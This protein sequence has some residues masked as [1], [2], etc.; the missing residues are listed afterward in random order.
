MRVRRLEISLPD[1]YEAFPR[2][3]FIGLLVSRPETRILPNLKTLILSVGSRVER[4]R[5][6]VPFLHDQLKRLVITFQI[7]SSESTKSDA[8]VFLEEI[9]CRATKLRHVELYIKIREVGKLDDTFSKFFANQTSLK[10][11]FMVPGILT[12]PV[13][14]SLSY[15]PGLLQI[16]ILQEG[17]GNL[18]LNASRS[19]TCKQSDR[20]LFPSLLYLGLQTRAVSVMSLISSHSNFTRLLELSIDLIFQNDAE[21]IQKCMEAISTTCSYLEKLAFTRFQDD[22]NRPEVLDEETNPITKDTIAS[23]ASFR[24]LWHFTLTHTQPIVITDDDLVD[25]LSRSA[26]L[27]E[28]CLNPCALQKPISI[29]PLP[30]LGVLHRIVQ[31]QPDLKHLSLYLSATKESDPYLPYNTSALSVPF[32]HL[33]ALDSGT[34]VYPI[35]EDASL[36]DTKN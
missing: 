25:L 35:L 19:I 9:A 24:S 26:R 14:E 22:G 28:L 27:T 30:T 7:G 21:D 8:E 3:S 10:Y 11:V 1:N 17:Y 2:K 4:L 13:F 23:L 18:D 31:H 5:Y 32:E 33:E 20:E 16:S 15:P 34:K 29:F 36:T 12:T 6:L